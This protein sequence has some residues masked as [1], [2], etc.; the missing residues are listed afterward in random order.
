MLS[1]ILGSTRYASTMKCLT[2]DSLIASLYVIADV[3]ILCSLMACGWRL[4][5]KRA[6]G[7]VFLPFQTKLVS[8]FIILVALSHLMEIVTLFEATY[9][10]EVMLRA[11]AA[12]LS[13]IVA[14]SCW[15]RA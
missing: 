4:W 3:V 5:I 1:E 2:N 6:D 11:A 8:I 13:V 14:F 12:G 15:R 7:Y 10:L 9:R